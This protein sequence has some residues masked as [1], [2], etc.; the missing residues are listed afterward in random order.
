[1]DFFLILMA[2]CLLQCAT[3]NMYANIVA[4]K[5]KKN[6]IKTPHHN[7]TDGKREHTQYMLKQTAHFDDFP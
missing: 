3:V 4:H 2:A 7:N 6:K 5:T 1:M